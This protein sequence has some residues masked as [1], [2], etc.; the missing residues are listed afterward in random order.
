MKDTFLLSTAYLAPVAYYAVL[1]HAPKVIIETQENYN[2]QSY[3]NRCFLGSEQGPLMLS[4]NVEKGARIKCPIREIRLSDHG[5]WRHQ[6]AVAIM[7]TYGRTPFYEYYIDELAPVW[8]RETETLLGLNEALRRKICEL[9]GFQPE[10]EYS[11]QY[12]EPAEG[13]RDLRETLH[14]K[15]PI[16]QALPEFRNIPYWQICG[17][18]QPFL[19]NMSILDLL[20]NMGPESLLV[21][22]DSI[23]TN[24][25]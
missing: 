24:D 5:E 25:N 12:T 6:H 11:T 18:R 22:R 19:P 14:P 10:V 23:S 9:I 13:I 3:R 15:R 2:K 4:I 16:G 17:E 20:F 1:Y 8:Q 21:L 7:S